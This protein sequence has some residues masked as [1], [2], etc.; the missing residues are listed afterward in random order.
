ML[1]ERE[2]TINNSVCGRWFLSLIALLLMSVGMQAEDYN[3]WVAGTQVTSDNASNVLG[4]GKVSWNNSS[5]TLTL[6]GA[7]I[8][9]SIVCNVNS[10]IT[11]HLVGTNTITTTQNQMPIQSSLSTEPGLTFTAAK[12]A[13]LLTNKSRTNGS[14]DICSGFSFSSEQ[15]I[16]DGYRLSWDAN[17][18]CSLAEYYDIY[19]YTF[20]NNSQYFQPYYVTAANCDRLMGTY[21][22]TSNQ[23]DNNTIAVS[24]NY[25][26]KTL[27]LNNAIF[28]SAEPYNTTYFLNCDGSKAKTLTINLLGENKFTQDSGE[29]GAKFATMNVYE[30][31]FIITTDADNPGSLTSVDLPTEDSEYFNFI[32][33]DVEY[34]NGLEYSYAGDGIRYIRKSTASLYDLWIDGEQVT[35][36][37]KDA[38]CSGQVSAG[39]ITF[40]GDHTLTFNNIPFNCFNG[41]YPFIKTSMDLTV[42][43]VGTS[44]PDMGNVFITRMDGDNDTHTLTF[45]T[46]PT[47]PG[48]FLVRGGSWSHEGFTVV[49]ENDLAENPAGYYEEGDDD[50]PYAWIA[51]PSLGLKIDGTVVTSGNAANVLGDVHK[52]VSYNPTTKTLT[53]K[54]AKFSSLSADEDTELKVYLIGYNEVGNYYNNEYAFDYEGNAASLTFETSAALPG[55]LTCFSPNVARTENVTYNTGLK[56]ESGEI[57]VT[58]ES[59]KPIYFAGYVSNEGNDD[60]LYANGGDFYFTMV[61]FQESTPIVS[62]KEEETTAA[63]WASYISNAELLLKAYFQFDWGECDNK[64]VTVQLKGMTEGEEDGEI[65]SSPISLST[66]NEDGLIEITL[67]KAMTSENIKFELSSDDAFSFVPM[68]V[69]YKFAQS[70]DITVANTVVSEQNKDNVLGDGKVSYDPET[71][72]LTLNNATIEPEMEAAGIEY[73]GTEDLT[74]S[75]KGNSMIYGAGGCEAIRYNGYGETTPDLI[76]AK[77]DAQACSLLLSATGD[78]ISGFDDI[79]YGGMFTINE[80]DDGTYTTIITS[81]LLGGGTGTAEDPFLIKTVEDLKNFAQYINS[82]VI[83]SQASVKLNNTI[84]CEELADFEPIGNNTFAFEG[85]FNGNN[86]TISNLEFVSEEDG[87]WYAGFFGKVGGSAVIEKLTLSNCTFKGGSNVGTIAAY[88]VSG[89]IRDCTVNACEVETRSSQNPYAG[90]V[91]GEIQNGTVQRCKVVGSTVKCVTEYDEEGGETTSGGIAGNINQGTISGCEVENSTIR[92]SHVAADGY[93]SA[94]GIVGYCNRWGE[95]TISISN[96]AVKGTTT[97]TSEDNT[98]E[99]ESGLPVAGAIVGQISTCTSLSNNTYEYSVT[100]STKPSGAVASTVSGYEQRGSGNKIEFEGT[101]GYPEYYD[102]LNDIFEDNGAVMYTKKVTL[103]AESDEASVVGEEGTYYSTVVEGDVPSILVAPGQTVTLNAMP[104]EGLAIASFTATNTTTS[105]AITT[106]ATIIEGNETQYTFTMPDAPVNVSLTTAAVY[107]ITVAGVAVTELN[108][109]DVLG[110]HK[111]SFDVETS[112]LTLNGATIN[113]NVYYSLEDELT[114]HLL[115]QNVIDGGWSEDADGLY[116]F[117]CESENASLAF[118]TDDENPGQL[119][120]KNTYRNKWGY[121][122]YYT[123]G[124]SWNKTYKNGLVEGY[125]SDEKHLIAVGPTITPGEGLYWTDQ[126]YT[127]TDGAQISC[128]DNQGHSVDVTVNA[129]SFTLTGT[130]KYTISISKAVTLDDSNFSLSNSGYYIVHNKPT[131]SIPEGTYNDELAVKIENLPTLPENATYYP[132]VWYYLNDDEEHPVQLTSAEQTIAVTES[133][134][135]CVYFIDEDSGKVVKSAPVEAEYTIIAKTQLNI[136]YAQNSR[137]W[138]SYC[139]TEKSLETPE[140][141]QAYV[142][143]QATKTGVQVEAIDYIPQGVGVLLKR[144]A[145]NISEPIMAKA[146]M[147]DE[148]ETYTSEL[149]GTTASTPVKTLNGTVYVLYND[150]FTRATSGSIG[151]HRGYLLFDETVAAGARLSIFEDETTTVENVNRETLT[152]NQYYNLNGQRV[153]APKKNGLYIVNGQKKIVK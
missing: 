81:T 109:S 111:V 61:G 56:L 90:G 3:L 89:T 136:S 48:Q 142:V 28:E 94:G 15:D 112:T 75:L 2:L 114:V 34:Q 139:A 124:F 12:G 14:A 44:Q 21:N 45:T 103:P 33:G 59:F 78:V 6:N 115:G 67:N 77:G 146:Y 86:C 9:G 132:Q 148:T 143:K 88:L 150:G 20:V 23:W 113:G 125:S 121:A 129:N 4:D 118:T 19:F 64:A 152:N 11:I 27:T 97:V 30:G 68:S 138:A 151:A 93:Q 101:D 74:I 120:M 98:P 133:T 149:V 73:T 126:E 116:A 130:G 53:L 91:T 117:V 119:L 58:N 147:E 102:E 95:E 32:N 52:S 39:V 65:Y 141:L 105:E 127:I 100:V 87:T 123:D 62:T 96:N 43:L 66:A 128:S 50:V 5:N 41:T 35:S 76:F 40:D 110:D 79:N 24:Y 131:Y 1:M 18:I 70:Y 82:G 104:G 80:V 29:W 36:A 144:T 153:V 16:P 13:M 54:G 108:Y 42:H 46:D 47:N 122:Q 84:N 85:T 63:M 31:K 57:S 140:G 7:T 55:T 17:E 60:F 38:I 92:S 69:G 71:N 51:Q 135:V 37:N 8:N 26:Q 137:T 99:G 72:T 107:G 134:K 106:T 83:S 25:N 10:A 22:E 145:D 49:Y